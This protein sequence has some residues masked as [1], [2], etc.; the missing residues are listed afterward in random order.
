M[1]GRI[2]PPCA[3]Q[4]NG[5]ACS[6]ILVLILMMTLPTGTSAQLSVSRLIGD[7]MVMQRDAVVPLWGQAAPDAEVR[8]TFDG[9]VHT[10]R[11]DAS[12]RWRVELA[13]RQAGGPFELTIASGTDQLVVRDVLF[14]DVWIASGQSNM[15]WTVADSRNAEQEIASATDRRIR[16]FKVPLSWA[17]QPEEE[18]AGGAWQVTSPELAATFSAIGYFFAREL[19]R[20]H[21]VPIG[22]IN[23]TWGGSRIEPWMSAAALGLEAGDIGAV[24]ARE[25]DREKRMLEDLR[26]RI[27]DLPEADAGLVEGQALWAD[28][29]LDDAAWSELQVPALW[30]AQ[31]FEGMDGVA[32]YRTSFDLAQEEVT[33]GITLGLGAIDDSDITWVNG[34][35]VGRM[36]QAWNRARRYQ[37]PASA[38][39]PG[40]NVIAVR[41]E[42][43][44]GGGGIYGEPDLLHIETTAGKR[45][46]AGT[47]KFKVGRIAVNVDGAKNQIPTLLYNRMIHP[48]LPYPIKGA[49][50]YQGESNAYAQDAFEYRHLF[51]RMIQDWRAAWRLGDFPFL[52]VQLAGYGEPQAQPYNSQW[53]VL[54]ESQSAAL[55]LPNT[56]QAVAIDIGEAHD[57]HP[58]N[59]QDVGARLALAARR[60][61][62]GENVEYSGPVYR[63]HEQR[64]GRIVIEFDHVGAGLVARGENGR[65]HGFAIAGTDQ[66]FV[67]ADAVI[68]GDRVVV[69]SEHVPDPVAVRYAWADFPEGINLFNEAGLPASPFRTDTWQ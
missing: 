64:D 51:Q 24:L 65:V 41:V 48:L 1:P 16:H 15:E 22:I 57:I 35:E 36:E 45:P 37:V 69:W 66:R 55:A 29:S 68:E 5:T 47:W 21:D 33:S 39:R 56:A 17:E 40:R 2:A 61:A 27:G 10:A 67:W 12:G 6:R 32:W 60:V 31:G 7:G 58:R 20:H 59:K 34:F 30:E 49:I 25:K 9:M 46:L 38:L 8:V 43:T 23:T 28:P 3:T 54:R 42:D 18:L 50:W 44:G 14:G 63:R 53:A 11:A 13:A 4:L 52:F 19:R 62:F 26:A